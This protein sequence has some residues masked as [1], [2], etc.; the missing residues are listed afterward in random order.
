MSKPLA[1]WKPETVKAGEWATF[2]FNALG[3]SARITGTDAPSSTY[4]G[5]GT[6]RRNFKTP[7]TVEWT[8]TNGEGSTT[9]TLTV[10]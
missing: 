8:I 6:V 4:T 2:D 3:S 10:V 7:G 9:A 5:A 1:Q